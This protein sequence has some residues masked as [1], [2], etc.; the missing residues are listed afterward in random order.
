MNNNMGFFRRYDPSANKVVLG[1][2]EITGYAEG[3]FIEIERD[4]DG[5]MTTVGS[6]G[7]VVR[8]RNLSR[9][10]KCT[11]TLMAQAPANDLL[12]GIAQD[13]ED[14]GDNVKDFQ[15]K[16]LNAN[17][18]VDGPEAWVMKLPKIERAKEAGTI[19]WVIVIANCEV[20]AGGNVV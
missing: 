2:L 18:R 5:F 17:V 20:I 1:G 3:T 4:E 14:T 19:Q 15:M 11:L 6:L 10:V 12:N 16:D 9:V 8:T 7:D 13:D